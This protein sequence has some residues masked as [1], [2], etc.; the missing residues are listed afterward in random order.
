MTEERHYITVSNAILCESPRS[1]DMT[2][3][4][5]YDGDDFGGTAWM[6]SSRS[7]LMGLISLMSTAIRCM[8]SLRVPLPTAGSLFAFGGPSAEDLTFLCEMFPQH[9]VEVV[10]GELVRRANDLDAAV[11]ALLLR[12]PMPPAEYVSSPTPSSEYDPE[13]IFANLSPR[14]RL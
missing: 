11:E 10:R 12:P 5:D 7:P 14:H 4:V 2:V 3:E 1:P 13:D 8:L 6:P 9:S